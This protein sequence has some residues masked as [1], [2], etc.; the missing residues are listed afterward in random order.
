MDQASLS[1]TVVELFAAIQFLSGYPAPDRL[2]EVHAVQQS[3]IQSEVCV[4]SC[5]VP[6]FYDPARGVF[7]DEKL[8]LKGDT[9]DRSILLHELV[10]HVQARSGRFEYLPSECERRNAEEREAYSIQNKYL[11]HVGNPR[12]VM[13]GGPGIR[14]SD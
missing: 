5:R 4:K 12:R 10:H 13:Y 3:W 14:C 9:F 7:I 2:P 11:A 8:D 6:A 1:S